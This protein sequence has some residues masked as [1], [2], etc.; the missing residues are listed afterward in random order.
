MINVRAET[1]EERPAYRGLV[2]HSK[3]RC[4]ILADGYYEW[5]KPEDPRQP[6]RP[7][8]FS[9]EDGAPFYFAGLWTR[10]AAPDGSVVPS[11]TIVTCEAN[12]LARPTHERMP[13]IVA[14]S[15]A[16]EAWLDP[17]VEAAATRELLLR[18]PPRGWRCDS[19]TQS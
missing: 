17:G 18:W 3:H 13:V 12:E 9:L 15:E 2:R 4:L 7:L 8:H 1:L 11:C 19:R 6:R 14:D 5:Q 10:W 16:S